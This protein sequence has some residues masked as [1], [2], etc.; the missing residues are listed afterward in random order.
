MGTRDFKYAR[1]NSVYIQN[2][3]TLIVTFTKYTERKA[4][5]STIH[6]KIPKTHECELIQI[7]REIV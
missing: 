1:E 7:E 6:F 5:Q 4:K 3:F 2:T